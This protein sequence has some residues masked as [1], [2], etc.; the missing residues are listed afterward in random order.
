VSHRLA[1][2]LSRISRF[3]F[4]DPSSVPA[5]FLHRISHSCS[6]TF[7]RQSKRCEARGFF[8]G[9]A[10]LLY[11]LLTLAASATFL[12]HQPGAHTAHPSESS[13]ISRLPCP[14][15]SCRIWLDARLPYMRK[16]APSPKVARASGKVVKCV[17]CSSKKDQAE[18]V[19]RSL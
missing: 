6:L 8:L 3:A 2:T 4:R 12:I 11:Y 9:H 5:T 17:H 14:D 19:G 15:F 1:I 10:A 18:I 16:S 7:R 13:G